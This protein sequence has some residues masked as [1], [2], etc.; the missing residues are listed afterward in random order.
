MKK[1]V[2]IIGAGPGGL[3]SGMLL[4][5]RG[6]EV[7]ILEKNQHVGGRSAPIHAGP[8]TFDTGPTF[9]HQKFT[10]EEIFA[11]TGRKPEDYLDLPACSIP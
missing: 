11:E 6:Y 1:R 8:Y 5:N 9:L 3:T 10:L 4:A 7:T 2:I